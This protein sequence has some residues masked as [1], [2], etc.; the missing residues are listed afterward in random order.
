MDYSFSWN[1]SVT[2]RVYDHLFHT[3]SKHIPDISKSLPRQKGSFQRLKASADN[4]LLSLH[5]SS[6]H[7]KE[8]SLFIERTTNYKIGIY[9]ILVHFHYLVTQTKLQK[10]EIKA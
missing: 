1:H 4:I 8:C 10:V 6:S 5:N 2:E 9:Y 7:K 3:T